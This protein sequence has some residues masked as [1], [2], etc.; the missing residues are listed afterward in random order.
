[1]QK[2]MKAVV[3]TGVGGF[4]KLDYRDVPVP[5]PGAGEALLQVLA[6]GV[7]NTEINT[8]IGW[9]SQSVSGATSDALAPPDDSSRGDGGW[10]EVTPFP[11]IQG[12]DC[13]GRVVSV[14]M[15]ADEA[16]IGRR[17]LVR[18]CIR[19][20]GW[21]S[22]DHH[23]MASDFDGAFAQYVRVPASE[24]FPVECD[25]SDVELG[26]IPCAYGT[27]ENLIHKIGVDRTD[28]VLIRGASGGV[29]SAAIQLCKRRGAEVMAVAGTSKHAEVLAIGADRV[30]DRDADLVAE[31]GESSVSKVVDCV[32]GEGFPAVLKVMRPGAAYSTS[33]AISGPIV[34]LDLRDLYLKDLRLVGATAWEREV[35]PNLVS[36]IEA[37]EIRPL[38]HASFP[39]SEI[40]RVQEE[41]LEKKHVGKYVLIPPP[42]GD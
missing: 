17:A 27:A 38:V 28:R 15:D 16:L 30:V 39:L 13:C 41:F 10:N 37:G 9:Y 29:G 24:V 1:M 14:G 35:F 7:N 8:R 32:G 5:E 20:A 11:F 31:L 34:A 42:I 4:D 26:S 40:A 23:W 25:W 2:T 6:A 22:L 18:P 33:G 36:Y 19:R 21:D 3:T 12:T